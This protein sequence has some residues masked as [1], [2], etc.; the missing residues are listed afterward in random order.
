MNL[1][2]SFINVLTLISVTIRYSTKE[3]NI[4]INGM[5]QSLKETFLLYSVSFSDIYSLLKYQMYT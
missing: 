3:M 1:F 2:G 4:N 5:L